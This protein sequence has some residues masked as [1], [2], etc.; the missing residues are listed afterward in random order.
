MLHQLLPT[1]LTDQKKEVRWLVVRSMHAWVS[2]QGSRGRACYRAPAGVSAQLPNKRARSHRVDDHI[3]YVCLHMCHRNLHEGW[4]RVIMEH[5]RVERRSRHLWCFDQQWA[6][7]MV[8]SLSLSHS[9][10]FLIPPNPTLLMSNNTF[11]MIF[12]PRVEVQLYM[13]MTYLVIP[14]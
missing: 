13:Y 3:I 8:W 1:F 4:R 10:E 9:M 14:P 5:R 11:V 7:A 2:S 12:S 6:F